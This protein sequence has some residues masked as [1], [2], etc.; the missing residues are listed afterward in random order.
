MRRFSVFGEAVNRTLYRS[1]RY[2]TVTRIVTSAST[3]NRQ[4]LTDFRTAFYSLNHRVLHND[5]RFEPRY[6]CLEQGTLKNQ[7]L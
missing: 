2:H 7:S 3:G 6:L 4:R 1:N 5:E